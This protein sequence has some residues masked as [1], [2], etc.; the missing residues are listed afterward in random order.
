M[1]G[2]IYNA[3]MWRTRRLGDLIWAHAVTNAAL[4]VYIVYTHKWEF[5][6]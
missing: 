2:I 5:W 6:L 1:A 3:W 4:C